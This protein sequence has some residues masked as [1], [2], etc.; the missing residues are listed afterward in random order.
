MYN[1]LRVKAMAEDYMKH[2]LHKYAGQLPVWIAV[3]FFDFGAVARLFKLMRADDQNVVSRDLGIK[4]GRQ[5]VSI[6]GQLNYVRNLC[7]H[8]SRLW[9]RTLTLRVGR[10]PAAAMPPHLAH[11]A[12]IEQ[13]DKV[14]VPLAYT[15]HLAHGL[16]RASN[17]PSRLRTALR[18]FPDLPDITP[19]SHMGFPTGWADESLWKS[20]ERG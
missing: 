2:N 1:D 8:H 11:V 5:L 14:Y 4:N 7:A 10:Y 16:D 3:E 19:E 15:A 20:H 18:K 12:G 17:W 13:R 9:N 6:L